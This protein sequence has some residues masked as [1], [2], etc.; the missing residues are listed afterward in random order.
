MP[1]LNNGETGMMWLPHSSMDTSF[2]AEAS[3]SP[4]HPDVILLDFPM[5]QRRPK[6]PLAR[7]GAHKKVS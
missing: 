5:L 4:S 6:R 2:G 3:A 7:T 1:K